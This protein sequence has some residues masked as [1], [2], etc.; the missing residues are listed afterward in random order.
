MSA[1][2]RWSLRL[3]GWIWHRELSSDKGEVDLW[4]QRRTEGRERTHHGLGSLTM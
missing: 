2:A 1:G 3:G 4:W